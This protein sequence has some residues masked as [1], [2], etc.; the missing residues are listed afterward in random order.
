[1]LSRHQSSFARQ[2]TRQLT[3][4][5]LFLLTALLP[6][7][8]GCGM[9]GANT[10]MASQ[11]ATA[12]F[13]FVTNSGSGTVSAF[14]VSNTGSLSLVS[15]APFFSGQGAEFLAFDSM[16]KLLFVSNQVANTVSAFLVNTSTGMLTAAPGSP[17]A[18]GA[19]PTG[20]AVDPMGRFVFVANQA[21]NS[22]S[23]FLIGANG[24]LSPAAGSPFTASS[25]FGLV[26]NAMGTVLFANN[27]PD[28]QT[29]DLNTVS[30][31][32]IGANGTLTGI[33]GSPFATANS[34]G[35][36]SSIGIAADPAGKFLFVADHMAQAVVPFNI[37]FTGA[38]TPV[39]A[40]PTPA[41]S[42]SVSCHSNPLRLTVH[43]NDQFVYSTNVQAGTVS[44]FKMTN[45]AL[46]LLGDV[47]TGQH[48]FGVALDPAG[49]FL[50]V[51]NKVDNSISAYSVNTSSGMVVPLAGAPFSG[52]MNAPTDIVVIA[53]Q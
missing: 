53:R 47:P 52:S 45:G 29:S 11:A 40:L 37:N 8:T 41:P 32:Q 48:P 3:F 18:T 27:F 50:F 49:A 28:L 21:S 51:V 22:I 4:F 34:P 35:F 10:M 19:R 38:L 39:S 33:S 16:H 14:A 36:A 2:N 43:P 6:L 15:G 20:I 7:F 9:G 25:P 30:S 13:A 17:F 26:V 5:S 42:C 31:F 24:A 44:A 1:M 23:V 12:S 46:S